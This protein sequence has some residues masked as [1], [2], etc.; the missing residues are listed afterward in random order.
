MVSNRPTV[1]M[2]GIAE[3]RRRTA[4]ARGGTYCKAG[5][6]V[7]CSPEKQNWLNTRTRCTITSGGECRRRDKRDEGDGA[8]SGSVFEFRFGFGSATMGRWGESGVG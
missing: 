5:L 7:M 1:A 2:N 3:Q 4:K 8:W 6:D